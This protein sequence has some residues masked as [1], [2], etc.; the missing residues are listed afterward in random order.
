[1][2]LNTKSNKRNLLIVGLISFLNALTFAAIIPIIYSYAASF[3]LNDTLIGLLFGSFAFA[4]FFATPVIGRLSDK[5]GRKPLLVIS[6]LGTFIANV[7]QA[8]AGSAWVLFLA[9][10]L[11][12][13]TGGNNSVAQAVI[14]DST[15]QKDRPM[16]F[17]IFGA[18]FGLGFLFGPVI[19][20]AIMPYGN[21]YVFLFSALIALLAAILTAVFLPETNLTRETKKLDLFDTLFLQI[22]KG[23]K[24]PIV[25][26][27][28]IINLITSLSLSVFQIAFQPYI[29]VNFGLGEEHISYVLILSGIVNIL[30]LPLVKIFTNKFGLYKLL[31]LTFL[32]RA[33]NFAI[34]ALLVDQSVF[35][36]MMVVFAFVNLFSRPIITSLLTRNVKSEDQGVAIGVSESMFSLG[37]AVGP[38]IFAFVNLP[39][40]EGFTFLQIPLI[41]DILI[42]LAKNY[43]LSFYAIAIISVI[44]WFYVLWFLRR[45]KYSKAGNNDF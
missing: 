5:Y 45:I 33:L 36:L 15:E 39:L 37:L 12:G 21:N 18:S 43:T 16:G 19:A 13:I 20:L 29:K 17:A 3:G 11:D 1:M 4:Q 32:F 28:L 35:W 30:F 41:T 38:A 40:Q 8:F 23:F 26:D 42:D 25:R 14:S 10:M 9:R 34:L 6:L 2:S 44:A 24:M 31:N 7:I 22:Y 27:I